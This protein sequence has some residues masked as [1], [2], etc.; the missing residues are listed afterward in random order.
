[1]FVV[2]VAFVFFLARAAVVLDRNLYW[3]IDN[4]PDYRSHKLHPVLSS[5]PNT[6][7]SF[8]LKPQSKDYRP[9]GFVKLFFKRLP[10]Y[11][12]CKPGTCVYIGS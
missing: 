2:V 4:S 11:R 6:T 7:F 10:T 1:M 5:V 3:S 8:Y 12:R 9:D